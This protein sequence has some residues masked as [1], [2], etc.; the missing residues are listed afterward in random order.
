MAITEEAQLMYRRSKIAQAEQSGCSKKEMRE[1][2]YQKSKDV[3][4][5][6]MKRHFAGHYLGN[7]E[8]LDEGQ[9]R[10]KF[11]EYTPGECQQ[12]F[13]RLGKPKI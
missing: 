1:T 4:Y 13:S 12:I 7:D 5:S 2:I 9:Q 10:E 6:W 11:Y 3:W 8:S